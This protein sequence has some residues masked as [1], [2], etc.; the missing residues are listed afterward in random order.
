MDIKTINGLGLA[1]KIK[2]TC[3]TFL[4]TF[5]LA[6]VG[7]NSTRSPYIEDR[8]NTK[9]SFED[10]VNKTVV[11]PE[12]SV[13]GGEAYRS[14]LELQE[15]RKYIASALYLLEMMP[16][17]ELTWHFLG[18]NAEK[19]G[20]YDVAAHYYDRSGTVSFWAENCSPLESYRKKNPYCKNLAP[21]KNA[22]RV[23]NKPNDTKRWINA[24]AKI[25]AE[26]KV[27]NVYIQRDKIRFAQI[28]VQHEKMM[29]GEHKY[30]ST[31]SGSE[32]DWSDIT[33]GILAIAAIAAGI[34]MISDN[35]QQVVQILSP[36]TNATANSMVN[37]QRATQKQI[38]TPIV[39]VSECSSDY[40]CTYGQRC[41]KGPM[42]SKG[43]CVQTVNQYGQP[44]QT[45]P[46]NN[47][48]QPNISPIGQCTFNSECPIG[49][50]CNSRIKICVK[51][52]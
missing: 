52:Q 51:R 24:K 14:S 6:L 35:P 22:E 16:N 40:Q 13:I 18:E 34:D 41:V 37:Q 36:I 46:R 17:Q 48:F 30:R 19:L 5:S 45:Q 39:Q 1:S 31:N 38:T 33:V 32:W 42:Q 11:L 29:S 9:T 8:T 23:K 4:L 27:A 3:L 12:S 25:E 47:S 15:R 2:T 20:L 7:C 26:I 49:F 21:K 50:E 10:F 28:R 44:I 43:L